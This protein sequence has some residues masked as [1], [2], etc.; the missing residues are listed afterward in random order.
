MAHHFTNRLLTMD[1]LP[2]YSAP[3]HLF[4]VFLC[5]QLLTWTNNQQ[6]NELRQFALN[7]LRIKF[8]R[9]MYASMP[10]EHFIT[11]FIRLPRV[12]DI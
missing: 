6:Q 3:F 10:T 5:V 2:T 7:I 11:P 4:T 1:R 12:W 8:L 9:T